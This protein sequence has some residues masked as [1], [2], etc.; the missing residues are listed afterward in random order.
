MKKNIFFQ[1]ENKKK[2]ETAVLITDQPGRLLAIFVLAPFLVL[3]AYLS[4]RQKMNAA[5]SVTLCGIGVVLFCY[6]VIWVL[7][8]E[9]CNR[10]ISKS[11]RL[12]AERW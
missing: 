5:F 1:V 12:R 10:C 9:D 11:S 8:G 3:Y 6:E 4:Q 7:L 2:M